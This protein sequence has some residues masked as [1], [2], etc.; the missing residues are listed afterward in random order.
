MK[1]KIIFIS[2]TVVLI[3][4]VVLM[5]IFNNANSNPGNTVDDIV[6]EEGKTNIYFFWGDGCP[7]CKDQFKF[8]ESIEEELGEYFN[9]FDFEVWNNSDNA[10]LLREFSSIL[11]DNV[12]GIPYTI[13]GDKS[14]TGFNNEIKNNILSAIENRADSDFDVYREYQNK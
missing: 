13:I 1:S 5:S 6:L 7:H 8:F 3:G 4:F 12:G 10:K 14:F 9:L 11:G 2:I